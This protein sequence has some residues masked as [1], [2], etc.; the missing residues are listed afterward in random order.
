MLNRG[1]F[2]VLVSETSTDGV[3]PADFK[4][5]GVL[6]MTRDEMIDEINKTYRF[7]EKST[8]CLDEEDSGFAPREGMMTVAQH[9]AH[10]AQT[11]EWFIDGM[12]SPKGFDTDFEEH[13]KAVMEVSSLES[14]R[15][16]MHQA[17]EKAKGALLGH[18]DAALRER[19]P[20]GPIM[21]GSPRYLLIPAIAEHTA[22]HRGALAVYSRV[23][24]KEPPIPYI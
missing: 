12:F 1:M 3:A 19:L 18:D 8:S 21:A 17:F 20:E 4:P 10:T 7:F 15:R 5:Q 16:W 11:V 13:M 22:H 24:G 9:V 14:A 2:S 6:V 23:L